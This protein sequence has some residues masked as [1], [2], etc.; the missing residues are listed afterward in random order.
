MRPAVATR[1]F[2]DAKVRALVAR[3][4]R[5]STLTPRRVGLPEKFA[6]FAPSPAH[7]QSAN[8]RLASID[9]RIGRRIAFLKAHAAAAHPREVMVSIALA[10][11]EVDRA[12]RTFGMLFEIFSQRATS[13]APAL[14]AHDAIAVDCYEAVLE[15][16]PM[17]FDHRILR[18]L[19]YME[20]G[21]SPATMRRGV[22]LSRLLGEANPFPVIRIPWDRDNPWQS[23]FLHEVAH[24]LQAD[25]G[26]WHENRN[27]VTARLARDRASPLVAAIY[28]RWHK[29]IFADL[30]AICLGGTASA[31][32]MMDFLAHPGP[33]ALTYKPGGAHPTGYLRAFI[34]A[35]MMRR[36]G[37]PA[38][39]AKAREV[40]RDLYGSGRAGRMPRPLLSSVNRI[41]PA[42]VDEIAFQPRRN[43]AQR[44][45]VDVIPFTRDQEACIR[46][47]AVML[48]NGRIPDLPPRHLVSASRFA[49]TMGASAQ[50]MS[51]AVIRHLSTTAA[52]G[53]LDPVL[54]PAALAA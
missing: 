25:L 16:A 8:R 42:V 14:A 51:D 18:P 5:L 30:A 50:A 27:A 45:L 4:R 38:D 7:F 19:T 22:S 49:L 47:G 34:L 32:G 11:R 29:E 20:H 35:E 53:R 40:W 28:R 21:Y 2:I 6:G 13:F 52:R 1:Q 43:L 36:L 26:I 41:I 12:R 46:R 33:K 17:V 44:A 48:A 24:N 23:V 54:G 9:K 39:A 31:W 10:E 37:F 15:N 3:S